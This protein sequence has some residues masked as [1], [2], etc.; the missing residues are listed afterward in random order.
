MGIIKKKAG[1]DSESPEIQDWSAGQAKV[2]ITKQQRILR[3][4]RVESMPVD[5]YIPRINLE[6]SGPSV[7]PII[8]NDVIT[9]VLVTCKCGEK[10]T[11][12]F[13]YGHPVE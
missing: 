11:V 8:E 9:G 7:K 6:D 13:D 12:F 5:H 3:G 10:T 1:K 4:D 2:P